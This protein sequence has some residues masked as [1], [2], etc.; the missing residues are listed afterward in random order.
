[1]ARSAYTVDGADEMIRLLKKAGKDGKKKLR[2]AG[3]EGAEV[4]V[5]DARSRAN[6]SLPIQRA[7][8]KRLM[9]AATLKGGAV[10]ISNTARVPFALAAFL[11]VQGRR[12]WY[13]APRYSGGPP[14]F[15][16]WIG[17][18]YTVGARS[19]GPYHVNIAINRKLDEVTDIFGDRVA[20]AFSDLGLTLDNN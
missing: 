5:V 16:R 14:Q 7:A 20:E 17:N 11:G 13:A 4:V 9:P 6:R 10:R 19:G 2:E 3:K 15:P 8:A 18:Q 1:M 12:G